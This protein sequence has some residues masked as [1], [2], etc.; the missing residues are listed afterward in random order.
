MDGCKYNNSYMCM[1]CEFKHDEKCSDCKSN[2][3]DYIKWLTDKLD[4]TDDEH[5]DKKEVRTTLLSIIGEMYRN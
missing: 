4:E 2:L 5:I 3:V 1:T